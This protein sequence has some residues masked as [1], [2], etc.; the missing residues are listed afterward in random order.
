MLLQKITALYVNCHI[1]R[2]ITIIRD[3][4]SGVPCL[5]IYYPK[6]LLIF[7]DEAICDNAKTERSVIAITL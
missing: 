6:R 5:S 3:K 7:N 2:A 1:C 4:G